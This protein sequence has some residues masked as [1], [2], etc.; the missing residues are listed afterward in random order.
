SQ[1]RAVALLVHGESGVGKSALVRRFTD[2][3]QAGAAGP[4]E[5][6]VLAG[7]CYERE[8]VP[9]KAFDGVVDALSRHLSKLGRAAAGLLPRN[10]GLLAQVFPVMRRVEAVAQAPI[11]NDVID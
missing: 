4:R 9:Y 3:I 5:P 1:E 7:R 6:L 10:A 11:V 2:G 8:S